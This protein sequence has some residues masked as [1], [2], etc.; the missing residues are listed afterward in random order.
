M[1]SIVPFGERPVSRDELRDKINEIID[2]INNL[3]SNKVI[4]NSKPIT[5]ELPCK[6]PESMNS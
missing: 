1:T 4:D 2:W 3:T 6:S 5:Y